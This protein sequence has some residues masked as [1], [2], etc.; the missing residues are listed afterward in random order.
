[1]TVQGQVHDLIE[2]PNSVERCAALVHGSKGMKM[3]P[4]V[5][6]PSFILT[7]VIIDLTLGIAYIFNDLAGH[8]Y[9]ILTIFLDLDG[10]A[11]L[12]TWYASIKWF[13]VATLLGIFAH[14]NVTLSQRK[15]WLLVILSLVFLALSLDEVAQIHERL[16]KQ[17]DILL[18]RGSRKHTLFSRTGIWMFVIG[19]P[20]LVFF[21]VLIF[22]IRS[23]FQRSPSALVKMLLGMAITLAGA[24]GVETLRNFVTPHSVY[25][26]LQ[27]LLEEWCEMLGATVLLWGSYELLYRYGFAF[28]LNRAEI[29]QS[30]PPHSPR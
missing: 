9:R 5:Y 10:E 6:I 24:I 23:Y 11:N 13:C 14:H 3:V 18:P 27:I 29:D 8:P 2:G 25:S 19:V 28:R 12:P 4:R 30:P 22:S 17:S 16:G 26:T 20:F 1:M 15:S 21:V 7:L